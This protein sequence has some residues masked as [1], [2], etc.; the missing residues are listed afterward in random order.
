M[1]EQEQKLIDREEKIGIFK[2][3]TPLDILKTFKSEDEIWDYITQSGEWT[4]DPD[5]VK[6][7]SDPI[8]KQLTL[9]VEEKDPEK[10]KSQVQAMI[11]NA[12]DSLMKENK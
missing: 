8:R 9:E 6:K 4:P 5:I 11:K 3:L 1:T 7:D 12:M 2:A 10:V